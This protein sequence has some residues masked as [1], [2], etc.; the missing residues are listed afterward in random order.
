MLITRE[1]DYALRIL[2]ILSSEEY[3]TVGSM[4]DREKFPQKFGYK[5]V[6]KLEKAGII[7]IVR[8]AGGG[9]ALDCDLRRITLYDLIQAVEVKALLTACMASGYE[10]EWR[11]SSQKACVIHAQLAK[12]QSEIDREFRLRSLYWILFGEES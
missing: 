1:T 3:H 8:G 4:A 7:R 2:R 11:E 5:I 12:V 6:K 10:C 9:C